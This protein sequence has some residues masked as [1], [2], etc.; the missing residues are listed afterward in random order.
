MKHFKLKVKFIV[1]IVFIFLN[2]LVF[3]QLQ[4]LYYFNDFTIVDSASIEITYTLEWINDTASPNDKQ[5]DIQK[6][7]IGKRVSKTYSYLLFQNDSIR[8]ILE[9]QNLN[10]PSPPSG[11]SSAEIIRNNKTGNLKIRHRSDETVFCYEEMKTDLGWVILNEKKTI[12]NYNCQRAVL[13]F[14]GRKYEAWFTKEIP[15]SLGPFKFHGLPGL[16]LEI[17]DEKMHYR[18]K[19]IGVEKLP[20][21]KLISIRNWD[22]NNTTREELNEFFN[23]KHKNPSNYYNSQGVTFFIKQNGKIVSNPKNYSLPY[24][25]IELE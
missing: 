11:A 21:N 19:C 15:I 12:E 7:L 6:L 5:F 1:S 4:R 3:G 25:P 13:T 24:N 14:R 17:N 18:Y 10:F 22:C 2:I 8:T 23:Q 20:D 16:I 9:N